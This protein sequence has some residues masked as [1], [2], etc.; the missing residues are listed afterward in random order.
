[1]R[2]AQRPC[3]DCAPFHLRLPGGGQGHPRAGL[4]RAHTPQA[5][6]DG[7]RILGPDNGD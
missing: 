2:C 6:H 7:C 4:A 1:M 5:G 3:Q